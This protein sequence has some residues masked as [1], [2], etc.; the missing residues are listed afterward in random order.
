MVISR[1]WLCTHR[2]DSP[3]IG[4]TQPKHG[5]RLMLRGSGV[6]YGATYI[7]E[8]LLLLSRFSRV[9]LCATLYTAARQAPLCREFSRQEYWSGL[10]CPPPG[11]LWGWSHRAPH[12]APGNCGCSAASSPPPITSEKGKPGVG[13]IQRQSGSV[14]EPGRWPR[15]IYGFWPPN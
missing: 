10:P 11:D 14:K 6:Y 5:T 9:R 12:T 7:V 4:S 8:R 2:K 1:S 13:S 3:W 15:F